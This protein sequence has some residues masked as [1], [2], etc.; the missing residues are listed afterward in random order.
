[1]LTQRGLLAL[2]LA[3]AAV[4]ACLGGDD[5]PTPA[6]TPTAT[7]TPTS[8]PE[9]TP[10]VM[11][12]EVAVAKVI[13]EDLNVRTGPGR[14]Y[15]VLGR[16]QPDDEVPVSVLVV[17]GLWLGLPGIG[18]T[19]YHDTWVELSIDVNDVPE[20]TATDSLFEFTGPLYPVNSV[21]DIPSVDAIVDAIVSGDRAAIAALAQTPEADADPPSSRAA[22]FCTDA[23]QPGNALPDQL[24]AFLTSE[25][26]PDTEGLRLYAVVGA[27]GA[28]DVNAEFVII[29]GFPGG[30]GRQVW[31]SPG[32]NG[33]SW[34]S[35]GCEPTPP[36][37]LLRLTD[38][39]TFFWLRPLVPEPLDPV[40]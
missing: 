34:F 7:P 22:S 8:T 19:T 39:E 1:M 14:E 11:W 5:D 30:E 31:V 9:P 20:A 16:L 36:G 32:G 3:A 24:D 13:T 17:S 6:P 21:S 2:L 35:L 15:E 38:A 29:F 4:T 23:V 10:T 28:D 40:E 25:V 12:P 26:A 18:W 37:G 33:L 27:P